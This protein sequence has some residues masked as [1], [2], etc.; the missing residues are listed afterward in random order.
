V[1]DLPGKSSGDKGLA[2][3]EAALQYGG[4]LYTT[5]SPKDFEA[6]FD[7]IVELLRASVLLYEN[8]HFSISAFVS[9]TA[10]EEIGKAQVAIFRKDTDGPKPKGRDPLKSHAAKHAMAVLPTVFFDMRL[11]HTIGKKACERLQAEAESGGFIATREAALY[12]ARVGNVF[13]TPQTAITS[14]RAWELL[15]LSIATLDDALVGWTNHT[16]ARSDEIDD[17]L[18]KA[19]R[20]RPSDAAPVKDGTF[21]CLGWGSLIWDPQE[22]HIGDWH[23]DGPRLPVEFARESGRNRMTLVVLENG[24]ESQVLWAEVAANYLDEAI[25]ELMGREGCDR[26]AIGRWPNDSDR[27]YS[28]EDAIGAW[29]TEKGF[30]GVVW[31]ALKAG[32]TKERGPV[33][34]QEEVLAYLAKLKGEALAPAKEYIEKAPAQIVTAYRPALEKALGLDASRHSKK[35]FST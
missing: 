32:F 19:S 15:L 22:L 2:Q 31:T 1:S 35:D 11:V 24:S 21:V 8:K 33:P 12:V 7:H 25:D 9:L 29:A 16:M 20:M 26:M 34:S 28:H 13:T 4:A 18:K 5:K 30:A 6:A 10:I 23:E 27:K 14:A 17:L 3:V